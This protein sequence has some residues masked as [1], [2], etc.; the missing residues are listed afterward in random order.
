VSHTVG[1][2]STR[3]TTLLQTS[4]QSEICKQSYGPPNLWESQV[5]EFRDSQL[6]VLGQNAICMLVLWPTTQY[7]IRGKVVASPNSGS[8]WVLWIQVCPWLI[9][10]PK[11]LELCTNQLVVWFVQVRVS[12]LMLVTLLSFISELQHAPLPLK[13]CEPRS[14]PQLLI[15]LLFSPYIHN[16]IYKGGWERVI[17]IILNNHHLHLCLVG[18]MCE[19][20]GI[21]KQIRIFLINN[22]SY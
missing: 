7:T 9:L 11:V 22:W 21:W 10:A 2:I 1:K 14:V 15:L 5:W 8:W 4:F 3:D 19:L 12:K 17:F 20:C 13:C 18:M 16:W 6:G